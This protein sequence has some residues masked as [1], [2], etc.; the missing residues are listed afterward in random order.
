MGRRMEV[1]EEVQQEVEL[2]HQQ[3]W[4][5]NENNRD[6]SNEQKKQQQQ[7]QQP[8]VLSVLCDVTDDALVQQAFEKV[9]TN[10]GTLFPKSSFIDLIIYN[11]A[12]PYPPGFK[13]QHWGEILQ[14]HQIDTTNMSFQIDTLVN[15]LVRVCKQTNVIPAMI[16]RKRGCLLI[17]G[18][19][20]C[21][22]HGGQEFGAVAPAR[23]AMRSLTQ[24]MFRSYGPQGIHVCNINI[25]GL[26]DTPRTR[27]WSVRPKLTNPHEIAGQFWNVYQQP[28]TVW[29]Y[30]LQITP[31]FSA[32]EVDMRM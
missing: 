25:G 19:S 13:F 12:P 6:N 9:N 8:R 20:C 30:E 7:Q 23:A 14:A 5:D 24:S 1:L 11:V 21:N 17:A 4:K 27:T 29:S 31:G 15:G 18:E 2:V 10:I 3:W 22:L 32:R 26:I 16:E 28:P